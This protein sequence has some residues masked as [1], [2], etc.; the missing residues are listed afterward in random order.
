TNERAYAYM[1]AC[2]QF[3]EAVAGY[4]GVLGRRW[5]RRNGKVCHSIRRRDSRERTRVYHWRIRW[6]E[7]RRSDII[8]RLSRS[9]RLFPAAPLH[10]QRE[11]T[12]PMD[13]QDKEDGDFDFGATRSEERR[14]G[15]ESRS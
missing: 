5:R 4:D 10:Q 9:G 8:R 6:L 2:G 14:V 3:A 1:E 15:K 12:D 7:I 13:G 11:K